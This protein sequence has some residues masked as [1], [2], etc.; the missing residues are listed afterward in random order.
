MIQEDFSYEFISSRKKITYLLITYDNLSKI[1]SQI[2][3]IKNS[4]YLY[5]TEYQN[6][7]L[8]N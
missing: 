2:M 5:T 1:L 7:S 3:V 8:N 4:A 6:L